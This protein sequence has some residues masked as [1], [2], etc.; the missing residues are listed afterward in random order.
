MVATPSSV[1]LPEANDQQHETTMEVTDE[2]TVLLEKSLLD[3]ALVETITTDEILSAAGEEQQYSES[4]DPPVT[5]ERE[6]LKENCMAENIKD[7][8]EQ[9]LDQDCER[10]ASEITTSAVSKNPSH[11]NTTATNNKGGSADIFSLPMDSLHS[12]ASFLTPVEWCE[13][14]AASKQAKKVCKEI[15]RRVRLHG[16]RC[17]SE[18]VTSWKLGQ[19]A[20]AKELAALYIQSGVPIYPRSLGHSYHTLLWRM[21]V[22]AKETEERTSSSANEEDTHQTEETEEQKSQIIDPFFRER[23]DF[24]NRE[25][26][27]NRVSYFVEKSVFWASKHTAE[28]DQRHNT[29]LR[30]RSPSPSG[31]DD[32]RSFSETVTRSAA[33]AASKSLSPHPV[34]KIPLR[35]HQHLLNQHLIGK[36]FVNDQDGAMMTPPISLSVDFFHPS[37]RSKS[38]SVISTQSILVPEN[39]TPTEEAAAVGRRDELDPLAQHGPMLLDREVH[40]LVADGLLNDDAHDV[41]NLLDGPPFGP[42]MDLESHETLFEAPNPLSPEKINS[43]LSRMDFEIYSSISNDDPQKRGSDGSQDVKRHLRSRFTTYQRRLEAF[44]AHTDYSSFD[45]CM[46]DFWDEFFPH[47]AGIHYFDRHTPVPRLSCLQKFLTKPCPK[48]IGTVQC[49]IERLKISPRGKGVNVKGRLFPTYEY[50]LFIRHRP[51]STSPY[52]IGDGPAPIRRDTVLMV[53]KNKGR[54]HAEAAGVVPASAS[55]KKGSNNYYLYT[56]QQMDV[57]AHFN[58][59]NESEKAAKMNHNGASYDPV[60]MSNEHSSVLLGRLQSNFIGTEF[61]IYTPRLQKR[62]RLKP[63]IPSIHYSPSDDELDYDSG[64]SSDNNSS[65][66]SRFARL[67]LRRSNTN[68]GSSAD[69]VTSGPIEEEA[70]VSSRGQSPMSRKDRGRHKRSNSCPDFPQGRQIRTNRRAIAANTTE[71]QLHQGPYLCEEEDG[72]ITYTANLLGSR[73]RIMDVCVPKVSPDGVPAAAWKRYLET[74]DDTDD[75]RMLSCFKQLLQRLSDESSDDLHQ[76][77]DSD[78]DIDTPEDFGLMALQNRPPW[79]NIELGSFVLNFGGR[80]SVASVK[81]FQLCDRNDHDRIMLQFGRIQGRHS[82]TMDFQHPL[83]AVQAFS[84]AISSLQSKISFG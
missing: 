83:S 22:E 66:K 47:T 6:D 65:R 42:D 25:G 16:F 37:S 55:S 50:R 27:G 67:T 68:A 24:R 70:S 8:S 57:D 69:S 14:G 20:D 43:I 81:N 64:V 79:W 82:F 41:P 80:V 18:V 73:P 36:D 2:N 13:F 56:P 71:R 44:L 10:P 21:G 15:I 49:E 39:V 4:V 29:S 84:I 35:V 78:E 52:A 9:N 76:D 62:P 74:C 28:N 33:M 63:E 31:G 60:I 12:V 51:P 40:E 75:S 7:G 32:R 19:Q 38:E 23:S 53:A 58:K 17:A 11:S 72:V 30:V 3:K 59:V 77:I 1:E 61:V 5:V 34:R 48:A 46:L 54:K 26:Y 45:E